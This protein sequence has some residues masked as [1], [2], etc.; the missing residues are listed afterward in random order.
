NFL[1]LYFTPIII[2]VG[3]I[4]NTLSLLVFSVT[5]LQRLSSSFYLCALALADLGFLIGLSVVWLNHISIDLYV[6]RGWCQSVQY[7]TYV[8][9]FLAMWNV[10]SFT[11]ER[12]II[13]YHPL[14]KDKY[15]TEKKARIV[16]FSFVVFS[17]VMYSCTL[18]I[19]D[20]VVFFNAEKVC[21]PLPK[22]QN[23]TTILYS[24]DTVF[25][26]VVPSFLIVVLNVRI[27]IKIHETAM[28]ITQ[29]ATKKITRGRSQFRTARMLLI[30]SSIF[31]LINLPSH[32]FRVHAFVS[33][34]S[35]GNSKAPADKFKWHEFFQIIY[36]LNFAINFF[37]Y[38]ACGRPFR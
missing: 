20:V 10:V 35:T 13:V 33:R 30:L 36:F 32:A 29:S 3:L 24:I 19:Y 18:W 6:R 25:G 34:F 1:N 11:A 28:A 9:G 15:C 37:I 22:Y 12:Y 2:I 26:C 23:V 21:S 4:G 8:C 17:L 14:Q 16:V 27:M 38:S 31:V 7:L 5:H